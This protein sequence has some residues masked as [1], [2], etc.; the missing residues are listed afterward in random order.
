[1]ESTNKKLLGAAVLLLALSAFTYWD[2]V[3]RADRFERGQKLLQSIDPDQIAGIEISGG[4]E[5]VTL[6]RQDD[7]FTLR[8]RSG[9]RTRND[10][11][12]RLIRSLLDVGLERRVAASSAA[13]DLGLGD[14][15]EG[16]T[17]VAFTNAT[18]ED[19]VRLRF[20]EADDSDSSSYVRR[21]DGD[22][23]DIFKTSARVFLDSAP[24]DY[25][26]RELMEHAASEIVSVEGR[27]FLLQRPDEGG[28]LE[29]ARPAG[30]AKTSEV[31]RLSS[32][33]N[34]LRFEEVFVADDPQ[35][36]ALPFEPVLNYTLDDQSGYV[37][38]HAR[39]GD[40]HFLRVT[41]TFAV[42]RIE[43]TREETDE[44]LKDKSEVL[45]RS[46]EVAQFNG[47]HGSWVYRLAE[48]DGEKLELAAAD[49]R[50]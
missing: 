19:M 2:E 26:D 50:E 33:I 23:T 43:I 16:M 24:L 49:L 3:H 46:D 21:L 37:L 35:V 1:M 39:Q 5:T 42:E 22:N 18:G 30:E 20:A 17:E 29:L 44:E 41:A 4:E 6:S 27:D 15:A 34:R 40:E 45:K 12:N 8:E 38:S 10:A 14:G 11:V 25:L 47:Y 9:Y 32:L 31:S 48:F 28:D 7:R 36:A 13:E